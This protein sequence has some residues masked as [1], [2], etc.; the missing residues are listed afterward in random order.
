MSPTNNPSTNQ[1]LSPSKYLTKTFIVINPTQISTNIPTQHSTLTPT[2]TPTNT[3]IDNPT[4]A[5]SITLI[6]MTIHRISS[7]DNPSISSTTQIISPSN[8][9]TTSSFKY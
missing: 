4:T 7:S 8:I 6:P 3:S 2:Y 1:T 9:A 5:N